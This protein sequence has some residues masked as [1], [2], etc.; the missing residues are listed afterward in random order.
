MKQLLESLKYLH[1]ENDLIHRDI[2]SANL[3]IDFDTGIIKLADFGV[4]GKLISLPEVHSAIPSYDNKNN[5]NASSSLLQVPST[6]PHHSQDSYIRKKS[7]K[8]FVG[9]PCWLAPEILLQQGYDTKVDIWSLGITGLELACGHP[10]YYDA[11]DPLTIFEYILHSPPPTLNDNAHHQHQNQ[12]H[13][14]QQQQQQ[15]YQI[16]NNSNNLNTYR[17]TSS[18]HDFIKKCLQKNPAN[19]WTANE[20]LLH[21]WIQN[22][23]SPQYL[24]DHLKTHCHNLDIRPGLSSNN[25]SNNIRHCHS[26]ALSSTFGEGIYK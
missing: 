15:Q 5:N 10:P 14:Y 9:S 26:A 16:D 2:K 3:L 21:P 23:P 22:A 4:S 11:K 24:A 7:R 6:H 8:S 1:D 25:I 19:R 20:A 13:Y 17:F 12:Y 18:F